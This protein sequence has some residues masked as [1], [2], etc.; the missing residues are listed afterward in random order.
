MLEKNFYMT[1]QVQLGKTDSQQDETKRLT[2]I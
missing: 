1:R 2:N